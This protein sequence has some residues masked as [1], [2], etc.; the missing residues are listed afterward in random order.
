MIRGRRVAATI[1]DERGTARE[2]WSILW[3]GKRK[4]AE[5][6]GKV[7]S[8]NYTPQ[9][10]FL[11]CLLSRLHTLPSDC[12]CFPALFCLCLHTHIVVLY[13]FCTRRGS[14]HASFLMARADW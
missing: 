14:A 11:L 4:G 8:S 12:F 7:T 10:L 2:R 1:F 13:L 3:G 6:E 9:Q 5:Q